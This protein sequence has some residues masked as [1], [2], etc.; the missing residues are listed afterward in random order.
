MNW[1]TVLGI[2][3]VICGIALVSFSNYVSNRVGEGQQQIEQGQ[4]KV[5]TINKVFSIN[6]NTKQF[7]KTLTDPA[8]QKI[9]EG[10]I[11][12]AA[13]AAFAGQIRVAGFV[14]IVLGAALFVYGIMTRRRS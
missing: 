7:G 3:I 2:I 6:S 14:L 10:K 11:Q 4:Q 9:D 5:D 8:Q 13:Y 12:V 1:K